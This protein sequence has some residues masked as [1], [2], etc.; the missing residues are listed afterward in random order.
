MSTRPPEPEFLQQWREWLR[1][2]TPKCCHTCEYYTNE[3]QCAALT[4]A[5][6]RHKQGLAMRLNGEG[7]H[8]CRAVLESY[9]ELLNTLPARVMYRCHRLTEKRI[10]DILAHKKRQAHD[11]VM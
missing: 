4:S 11:V 6:L 8:A 10:I 2:G 3:G 5:G 1:A 9:A 7:I